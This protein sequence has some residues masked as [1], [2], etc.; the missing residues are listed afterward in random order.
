M[1]KFKILKGA[2]SPGEQIPLRKTASSKPQNIRMLQTHI[3]NDIYNKYC[4]LYNTLCRDISYYNTPPHD[5]AGYF[6]L[7]FLLSSVCLR[8]VQASQ[9]ICEKSLIRSPRCTDRYE[10]SLFQNKATYIKLQQGFVL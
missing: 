2:N 10:S 6:F 3:N 8:Y 7:Y 9:M 1:S 5:V 4:L